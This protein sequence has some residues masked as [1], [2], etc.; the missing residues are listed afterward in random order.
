MKGQRDADSQAKKECKVRKNE[1]K[2]E[3]EKIACEL[4]IQRQ[5][6]TETDRCQRD[7]RKEE[8]KPRDGMGGVAG[9]QKAERAQSRAR[10][11]REPIAP[12]RGEGVGRRLKLC[13]ID[14][15]VARLRC[16]CGATNQVAA[17]HHR[18]GNTCT[19]KIRMH[20]QV[21]IEVQRVAKVGNK[22]ATDLVSQ[23]CPQIDF[24]Y[25]A[26][27]TDFQVKAGVC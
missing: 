10:V 27:T 3:R 4:E 20:R 26:I 8:Q 12:Q 11:V 2:N 15:L 23:T 19:A 1:R 7:K 13:L 22:Y 16:A 6:Q 9:K 21:L 24:V 25:L 18:D 5:R 17:G 14:H